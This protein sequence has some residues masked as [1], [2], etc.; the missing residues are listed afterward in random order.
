MITATAKLENRSVRKLAPR[1]G[2]NAIRSISTAATAAAAIAETTWT[3]NGTPALV[4]EVQRVAGDGDELAVR[5]VDEPED[6]EDHRQPERQQRVGRAEAEG[7]DE[8]LE[9]LLAGIRERRRITTT[10]R[11][12]GRR[13]RSRPRR[14]ARRPGPPVDLAVDQDVGAVGDLERAVDVLL[15]EQDR[16]P[17]VAQAGEELEDLVDDD[18]RQPERRLVEQEQPRARHQRPADREHLLLAAGER[19]RRLPQPLAAGPG[20]GR[21]RAPAPRSAAARSRCGPRAEPQVVGHRKPREDAPALRRERE[22][23]RR[24]IRS[25]G[26]P[27]IRSPSEARPARR[28][29]AR[30]PTTAFRKHDLPA[31]FAPSRATISPC[32]TRRETSCTATIGP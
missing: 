23:P 16:R 21:A 7:V 4:L 9:R 19:A 14:A 26:Q 27:L 32:S 6:R 5:E 8:L 12:R 2:R 18:R 28:R 25:G 24:T 15:D 13:A 17:L 29:P 31:P 11:S 22:A 3:A 30:G 20:T 1:S 10:L